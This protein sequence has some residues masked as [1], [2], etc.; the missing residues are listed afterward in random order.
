MNRLTLFIFILHLPI[1][2]QAAD[3]GA[4]S[5][6]DGTGSSSGD[7]DRSISMEDALANP[8]ASH[9]DISGTDSFA[10]LLG[11]STDA[12]QRSIAAAVLR[13]CVKQTGTLQPDM[14]GVGSLAER[15]RTERIYSKFATMLTTDEELDQETLK[16]LLERQIAATTIAVTLLKALQRSNRGERVPDVLAKI[17]AAQQLIEVD[18]QHA[19]PP[20]ITTALQAALAIARDY[21]AHQIQ[22]T[23]QKDEA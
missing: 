10:T 3:T 11:I 7:F 9:I 19:L 6:S 12:S 4:S 18:E 8:H 17:Q 20:S 16:Q 13:W 5:D 22:S 2:V 21:T 23:P 15:K 1:Y 14:A